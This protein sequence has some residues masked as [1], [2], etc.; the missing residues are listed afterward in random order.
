[1]QTL[2][3]GR[4]WSRGGPALAALAERFG[5]DI[6]L[7]DGKLDR[8]G[9]RGEAFADEDIT[10]RAQRHHVAHD[11]RRV[12]ARI[13]EAPPTPSSCATSRCSP[14]AGP[15]PNGSTRAVIVVEA[16]HDLRLERLENAGCASDDGERRMAAQ[17][18]DDSPS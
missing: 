9:L 7:A 16:P 5:N 3:R 14:R 13:D 6:L 12:R 11:R 17:A 2:H 8:A 18:S 1:M 10:P 4:S 15:G